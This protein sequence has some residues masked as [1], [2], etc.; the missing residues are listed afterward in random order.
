VEDLDRQVLAGLAEDRLLFLLEDLACPV[1]RVYDGVTDLVIDELGLSGQVE[2]GKSLIN[3]CFRNG[4]LLDRRARQ[5][6]VQ[7][8]R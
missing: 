2:I 8:C 5:R 1:V 7:V 4:V 3:R 6:L